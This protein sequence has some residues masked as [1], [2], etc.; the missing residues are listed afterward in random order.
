MRVSKLFCLIVLFLVSF[1]LVFASENPNQ[2]S[3]AAESI[4]LVEISSEMKASLDK[5]HR[6]YLLPLGILSAF[7]IPNLDF[8]IFDN[9]SGNTLDK[10]KDKLGPIL[11]Q[12][13]EH[14]LIKAAP[15]DNINKIQLARTYGS[16]YK[17]NY[18]LIWFFDEFT[19]HRDFKNSISA[20]AAKITELEGSKIKSETDPKKV[21]MSYLQSKSR[22]LLVFDKVCKKSLG[23]DD[24]EPFVRDLSNGHVIINHECQNSS[25]YTSW[26]KMLFA[27]I[28]MI[29]L[30]VFTGAFWCAWIYGEKQQENI[31]KISSH[32]Y[33][34]LLISLLA[35]CII[36]AVILVGGLDYLFYYL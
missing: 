9:H 31:L 30:I 29:T 22:W 4:N 36:L 18:D 17:D 28:S 26:F 32:K 15:L 12:L 10:M 6:I 21:V 7:K 16:I 14:S 13:Q 24:I 27:D 34:L 5:S 25:S 20:L 1:Q 2:I 8:Q 33:E 3:N 11:K 23:Y 19:K 35:I